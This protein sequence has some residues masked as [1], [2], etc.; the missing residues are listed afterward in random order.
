MTLPLFTQHCA[1]RQNLPQYILKINQPINQSSLL[2]KI[3]QQKCWIEIQTEKH[4][5]KHRLKHKESDES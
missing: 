4:I 2:D 5:D 3:W 1:R